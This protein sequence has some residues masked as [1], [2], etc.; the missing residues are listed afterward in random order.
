MKTFY[1]FLFIFSLSKC[2]SGQ[3]S[4]GTAQPCNINVNDPSKLNDGRHDIIGATFRIILLQD[5]SNSSGCTG[6][7]VNRNTSDADV[8]FY[9]IIAK[10]CLND[11]DLN[12]QHYL[13]F[14]YQSPNA[15]NNSVPLSNQGL[16]PE[17]SNNAVPNGYEYLHRSKLELILL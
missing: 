2:M 3:G 4:F 13:S 6:T 9:F 10:H 17:Q 14:N 8:G 5:G 15:N 11:I 12:E 16:V 1:S 7:L